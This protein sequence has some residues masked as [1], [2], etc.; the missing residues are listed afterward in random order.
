MKVV[1]GVSNWEELGR[2][3]RISP[4][5]IT[6][7]VEDGGDTEHCREE[8]VLEWLKEDSTASW[9]KLCEVLERMGRKDEVRII[10]EQ[11]LQAQGSF[12]LSS[13]HH[14]TVTNLSF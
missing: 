5:K 7:L 6:Q 9:E 3:L 12:Y 1:A 14:S 11:Y 2:R 13:W 4:V 10:N 8:V